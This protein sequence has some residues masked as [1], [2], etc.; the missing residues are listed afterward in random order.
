M[1]DVPPPMVVDK[2]HMQECIL[3]MLTD[4]FGS[5]CIGKLIKN[6]MVEVTI[7][8]KEATINVDSLVCIHLLSKLSGYIGLNLR[9]CLSIFLLG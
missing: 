3:E 8:D 5:D 2:S 6:N 4:M 7:D 1:T 9:V